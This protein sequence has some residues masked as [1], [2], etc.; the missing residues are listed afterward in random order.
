MAEERDRPRRLSEKTLEGLGLMARHF[1]RVASEGFA[2]HGIVQAEA[3]A[4]ERGVRW[5]RFKQKEREEGKDV[6]E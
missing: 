3:E 5:I 4:I 1:E 2:R 6:R